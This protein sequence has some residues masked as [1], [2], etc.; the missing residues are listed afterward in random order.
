LTVSCPFR[1][2]YPD[3]SRPEIK[4]NARNVAA[5]PVEARDEAV[6]DWIAPGPED[7][8][9]RRGC[10]F[11]R[12][13]RRSVPDDHGHLP[14]KC[15][16]I[17]PATCIVP[18]RN[19]KFAQR[20]AVGSELVGHDGDWSDAMLLHGILQEVQSLL[21]KYRSELV[22]QSRLLDQGGRA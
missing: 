3:P 10:G 22:R 16:V 9:N 7:Y 21:Q 14:A 13:R 8:R 20:R 17:L 1:K 2:S 19:T 15:P 12:E 11:G 5:R 4:D 18:P 6:P